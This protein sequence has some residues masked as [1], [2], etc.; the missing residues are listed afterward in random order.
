M[1]DIETEEKR[2]TP[3]DTKD[4]SQTNQNP[5]VLVSNSEV[6]REA[7]KQEVSL[8]L[9]TRVRKI[10]KS[11][12]ETARNADVRHETKLV[13][14]IATLS[15]LGQ[16]ISCLEIRGPSKPE[17]GEVDKKTHWQR[18]LN[19]AED[20]RTETLH[21]ATVLHEHALEELD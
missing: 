13:E 4:K 21:E 17:H 7:P 14:G 19:N 5:G 10:D 20:T 16:M 9:R 3:Y 1:N 11:A 18:E 6:G 2:V 8:R 12:A 15:Q